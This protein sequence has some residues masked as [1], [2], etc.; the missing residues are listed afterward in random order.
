[1]PLLIVLKEPPT[2]LIVE[3]E[4]KDKD[5]AFWDGLFN[6]GVYIAKNE[7]GQ[8]IIIPLWKE[9][10]VT[11]I[12]EVTKEQIEEQRKKAEKAAKDANKGNRIAS[13]GYGFPSGKK[14]TPGGGGLVL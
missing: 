1:M 3:G 12:Q 7:D 2:T 13:P 8:S 10:N 4:I 9:S 6:N 11:F 5:D 14:R